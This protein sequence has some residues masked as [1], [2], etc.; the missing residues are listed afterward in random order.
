MYTEKKKIN[1]IPFSQIYKIKKN[2]L[3]FNECITFRDK[4]HFSNCGE[5]I[6]AEEIRIK[7][8]TMF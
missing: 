7:K 6:I 8:I 2:F 1:F 4:D 5:D 3:F